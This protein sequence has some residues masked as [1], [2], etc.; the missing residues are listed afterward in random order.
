MTVIVNTA[1]LV[2][3]T[4]YS[5]SD[6]GNH[7]SFVRF[8]FYFVGTRIAYASRPERFAVG[9]QHAIR[10]HSVHSPIVNMGNLIQWVPQSACRLR[11]LAQRTHSLILFSAWLQFF[12]PHY[13]LPASSYVTAQRSL[14]HG[15]V[16]PFRVRLL[17]FFSVFSFF[18]CFLFFCSVP[19][20]ILSFLIPVRCQCHFRIF[21]FRSALPRL[22]RFLVNA[23]RISQQ[24]RP[25]VRPRRIGSTPISHLY[26]F[27]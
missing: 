24:H 3:H 27:V 17:V 25:S 16:W 22:F 26:D 21:L 18:F 1:V 13:F 8:F 5:Q 19:F 4:P 20:C 2:G 10:T 14:L 7:N 23:F 9:W 6:S 12:S 15:F 11:R